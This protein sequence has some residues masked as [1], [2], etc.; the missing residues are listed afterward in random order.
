MAVAGLA[1]VL[2]CAGIGISSYLIYV[3][4]Q[5]V[6]PICTIV[7]GCETVQ[8]SSYSKVLGVPVAVPGILGY[9]ALAALAVAWMTNWRGLHAPATLAAFY[10]ALFGFLFSMYLTYVE[11][12]VIHAWCMW[13]IGSAISMSIVFASWTVLMAREMRLRTAAA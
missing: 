13:C 4:L 11:W 3:K 12:Q 10:I 5:G 9:I 1:L 2:A 6:A 8:A 7:H